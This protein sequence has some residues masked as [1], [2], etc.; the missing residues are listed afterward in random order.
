MDTDQ[1]KAELDRLFR[2]IP[3]QNPD[4]EFEPTYP[5]RT[6]WKHA[7]KTV[8]DG[9][10]GSTRTEVRKRCKRGDAD[11]ISSECVDGQHAPTIDIDLPCRLYESGTPGHFHLYIDQPMSWRKYKKLLKALWKAGVVERS[12]YKFATARKS[13]F[14]RLPEHPKGSDKDK[15][16]KLPIYY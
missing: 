1:T 9:Y 14:L 11:L 5:H 16:K 8:S 10:G 6:F 2:L 4:A 3:T 15:V 13:S 7:Y 12:Y